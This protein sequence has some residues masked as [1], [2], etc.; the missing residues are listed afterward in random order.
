[1]TSLTLNTWIMILSTGALIAGLIYFFRRTNQ[2]GSAETK[3]FIAESNLKLLKEELSKKEQTIK[4]L[5]K[6]LISEREE[7][8][9]AR[10]EL[11]NDRKN[12]EEKK[13]FLNNAETSLKD[14]FKAL[15]SDAL[16]NNNERFVTLAKGNLNHLLT[17]TKSEISDK[18]KDLKN[19]VKPLEESLKKFEQKISNLENKREKA[20]GSIEKLMTSVKLSQN[21]L[22]KE[23]GNLSSALRAPQV[24]GRWGELTLKRVVELAGM[25]DHCDYN[26]QPSVSNDDK[27]YQPDMVIN[28]PAGRKVI[29]DSKVPLDAY[30]DYIEA[31]TEKER[32]ELLIKHAGQVRSRMR[33]LASK[34]YWNCFKNTIEFVVMFIPGESFVSAALEHDK[35]LIE[36]GI[37]NRVIIATPTTLV[38]L[39]RAIAHGWRQEQMTKHVR[40]VADL[41]KELY[42]RFEP[43]IGHVNTTGNHLSKAIVS[44]NHMIM[45]LE[46]RVL[47]NVRKFKDMGVVG[48][49]DLPEAENIEQIPMKCNEEAKKL[50]KSGV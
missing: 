6:E 43:F 22:Q 26:E 29:I 4:D 31:S 32:K 11:E 41:A 12:F 37:E 18:Q 46:K 34:E 10:T 38:A 39:L 36:D 35:S 3:L 21:E 16:Q 13:Q 30:L 8:V 50:D 2:K 47:V 20:Y 1:M 15:S 9:I 48:G 45:S 24:R 49:E 19:L 28:L 7:K 42:K 5:D 23:T 27:R 25:S 40:E 14:A 33:E 17:E 44:F